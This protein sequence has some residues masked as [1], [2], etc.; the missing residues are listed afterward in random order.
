MSVGDNQK[1]SIFQICTRDAGNASFYKDIKSAI[2]AIY[3]RL[4]ISTLCYNFTA[5]VVFTS[6]LILCQP[7]KKA[8]IGAPAVGR[9]ER[10]QRL[11]VSNHID[12]TLNEYLAHY[13]CRSTPLFLWMPNIVIQRSFV[14]FVS[15]FHADRDMA[16]HYG[17]IVRDI[18]TPFGRFKC[19]SIIADCV[20]TA[21]DSMA[22]IVIDPFWSFV[23][24]RH[25]QTH[26]SII[27][28]L[29]YLKNISIFV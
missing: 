2:N 8:V 24:Y 13:G 17:H 3:C 5:G 12:D 19:F 4:Y 1:S 29:G 18:G 9:V 10:Q 27:K 23:F 26:N 25:I 14:N 22:G 20:S 21:T 28:P 6:L 11:S 15:V 7:P 16:G